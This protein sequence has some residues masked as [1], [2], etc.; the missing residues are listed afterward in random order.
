MARNKPKSLPK[1]ES[2]DE[3]VKFFDANDMGDYWE[4]LPETHFDINIKTRKHL[5]A[6]DEE[7]VPK[8]NEVAKSRNVSSEKLI[9]KWL[10][11]KLEAS[12][13]V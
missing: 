1:F 6:I 11:E 13:R 8:L 7:I 5:V 10:R 3:L 4:Q 2:L 9:N 12:K